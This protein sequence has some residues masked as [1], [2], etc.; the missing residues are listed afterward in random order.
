MRLAPA[1]PL[2]LAALTG[3]AAA[4]TARAD[5]LQE[6]LRRGFLRCGISESGPGF[7]YVDASGARAGLE[8]DNCR[9]IS[10]ALF[11]AE[12]IEYVP[13]SPQT[14]FTQIQ[15]GGIDLFAGGATWSFMRDVSLGIDFTG[16]Y[17]Y[18]GQGFIVPKET[19]VARV[20]D[21]D[22]ATICVTQGTTL[23]QNLADWFASRGLRYEPV[24]FASA[25]MAVQAYRSRRCDALSMQRAALGARRMAMARP[26]DHVILTETI[27]HEPQA[28]VVR[29]REDRWR[30]FVTWTFNVRLAAEALGIGQGNLEE[31]RARASSSEARRLLGVQ[32][33]FGEALGVRADWAYQV[34][35]LV[36][37][38]EDVWRRNLAPLGLER[39]PNALVRDGGLMS[40]LPFR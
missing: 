2:V 7:N 20:A 33:R 9:T 29:Q 22:G 11:G 37:N 40:P 34:I 19:G 26:Q 3:L 32:G 21:L 27:S 16:V 25:E 10:A 28:A 1:L 38:H 6:V 35:R 17:F 8:V 30:D 24:T 4:G 12:R 14:V 15:L 39:G 5:L 18:D 23:E 31:M 13:V 36:G